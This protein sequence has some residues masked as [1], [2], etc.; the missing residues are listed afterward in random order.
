MN[1]LEFCGLDTEMLERLSCKS[2]LGI[3]LKRSLRHFDR[4]LVISDVEMVRKTYNLMPELDTLPVDM[5]IKSIQSA[6][7]KYDRYLNANRPAYKVFD[8]L[9]GFRLLCDNYSDILNLST[10]EHIRIID[11]SQGKSVDDGYRGVHLYFQLSNFHYPIEVQFNTDHDRQFNDWLH[12]Y[13]Y[14]KDYSSE[15]GRQLRVLY[16]QKKIANEIQFKEALKNVSDS[17]TL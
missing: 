15:V 3:S 13:I 9:L 8:D 16:E 4:E 1:I 17:K 10:E 11:M 2:Q 5:R 14:K 7:L 12:K 6:M